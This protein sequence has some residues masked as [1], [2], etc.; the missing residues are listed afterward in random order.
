MQIVIQARLLERILQHSAT[1]IA[2]PMLP[3]WKSVL[4]E[5]G[6]GHLNTHLTSSSAMF[7]CEFSNLGPETQ[8]RILSLALGK[9]QHRNPQKHSRVATVLTLWHGV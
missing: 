1:S 7:V 6:R 8:H 2:I 3:Q 4:L 9:A 5:D